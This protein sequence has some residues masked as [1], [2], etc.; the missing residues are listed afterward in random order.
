MAKSGKILWFSS[1]YRKRSIISDSRKICAG[2]IFLHL[3]GC[4]SWGIVSWSWERSHYRSVRFV[5]LKCE[6]LVKIF[7]WKARWCTMQYSPQ[8][9]S[10]HALTEAMMCTSKPQYHPIMTEGRSWIRVCVSQAGNSYRIYYM[11]KLWRLWNEPK[12][13]DKISRRPANFTSLPSAPSPSISFSIR[14][15]IWRRIERL[16]W[17]QM[18]KTCT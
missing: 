17:F 13:W 14:K 11:L 1:R 15:M 10:D 9:I 7:T 18:V 16:Y 4:W 6:S 5:C 12:A 3:W 8:N 2:G